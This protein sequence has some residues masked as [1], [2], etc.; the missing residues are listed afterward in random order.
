ML[1]IK[2]FMV[3]VAIPFVG[4]IGMITAGIASWIAGFTELGK[5]AYNAAKS[6]TNVFSAIK[7]AALGNFKQAYKDVLSAG[8]NLGDAVKH[9]AGSFVTGFEA[10]IDTYNKFSKAAAAA[11]GKFMNPDESASILEELKK[12]YV[13]TFEGAVKDTED[14]ADKVAEKLKSFVER[15]KT[16]AEQFRDALGLFDKAA[17]EKLSGERLLARLQGQLKIFE[18]WST[19]LQNL[20]NRLGGDSSLFQFLQAQGAKSA[21]QIAGLSKLSDVRLKEYE[22]LFN[23]KSQIGLDVAGSAWG[24]EYAKEKKVEQIVVNINGGVIMENVDALVQTITRQ[25]QINGVI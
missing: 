6:V 22:S 16:Q 21:G 20:R 11:L 14:G 17:E 12:A 3:V 2:S 24:V 9:T 5:A 7:N 10:Y 25:L 18:R 13:S 8:F 23:R 15:V 19:N 4:V 1:L